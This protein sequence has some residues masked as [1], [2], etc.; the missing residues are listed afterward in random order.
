MSRST[1]PARILGLIA[2]FCFTTLLHAAPPLPPEQV[3]ELT[4]L[5]Q[6]YSAD[7][8][9]AISVRKQAETLQTEIATQQ[10]KLTELQGK[11]TQAETELGELQEFDRK[12]PGKVKPEEMEAS[13][14]K[15]LLFGH[16]QKHLSC[17][18]HISNFRITTL[19]EFT[20]MDAS[21]P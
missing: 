11:S 21:L 4:L 6:T 9:A 17:Y 18:C 1:P 7:S 20:Y 10:T 16:Q 5:Y 2:G 13:R 19:L 3:K 14:S 15:H 8:Q 12:K